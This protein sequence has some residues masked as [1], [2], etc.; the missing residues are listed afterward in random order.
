M[1]FD[2]LA[3]HPRCIFTPSFVS[4]D[5]T[6]LGVALLTWENSV[7]V[8]AYMV[9]GLLF[10]HAASLQVRGQI[11]TIGWSAGHASEAEQ[12]HAIKDIGTCSLAAHHGVCPAALCL[13][14]LCVWCM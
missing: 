2:V 6:N 11:N 9:E 7:K 3:A 4:K 8:K 14:R 12:R 1:I 13:I 5:C 10:T